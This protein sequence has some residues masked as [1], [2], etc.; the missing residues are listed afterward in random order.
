MIDQLSDMPAGV[1]GIR[2]SSRLCGDLR[3]FEPAMDKLLHHDEI[4]M[5]EVIASD[6]EGSSEP[7]NGPP[8][9]EL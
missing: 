6:Y 5:V 1:T 7:K 3:E 4:R 2:V 9:N 8:A